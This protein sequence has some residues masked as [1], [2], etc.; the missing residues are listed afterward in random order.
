[1]KLKTIEIEGKVY[2]EVS[3]GKPVYDDN[4][5]DVALDGAGLSEKVVH[6][7]QE[8]DK[9]FKARDDAKTEL[10]KFSDIED[11]DA[12][13]KAIQ[14][15]KNLD[16]K[17]LIDAG[18]VERVK[19]E[20]AKSYEGQIREKEDKI[21]S[22]ENTLNSE[23][24]G[25]RFARSKTVADKLAIPSDLVQAKFGSQ[26]KVEDGRVTAYDANGNKVYSRSNPGEL[27]DFDEALELI[28]DQYPNK[29]HILKASAGSGGGAQ[30]GGGRQGGAPA[31]DPSKLGGT[32]EE[33]KAALAARFPDISQS[34]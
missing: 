15:V 32:R 3:D 16:Q 14:T 31:Y 13:L 29:E 11:V 20:I 30:N 21:G 22:L 5:K 17:K 34:Q 9:A 23:M 12:A 26:F 1:M 19:Q 33:R 10:R 28:I 8:A 18:E 4:G 7:K 24:I 25:G 2:A 27:A 6:L